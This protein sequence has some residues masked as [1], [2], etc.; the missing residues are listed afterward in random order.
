MTKW[1][2]REKVR[3]RFKA[4]PDAVQAKVRD[5]LAK[6]AVEISRAQKRLA[7]VEDGDLR[8]SLT[9]R[10]ATGEKI[11]YAFGSSA[12]GTFGVLVTA[13]NTKVRYAH[14]VEFGSAPH[15]VGGIFKGAQHPG[16]SPQPFFFP[17]YRAARRRVRARNRRALKAAV[18]AS[19]SS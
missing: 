11:K 9:W 8:A 10:W 18:A 6:S 3:R 2:G 15:K 12:K 19:S 16:T 17:A 13:G 7:P 4:L 14:I 1:I 5:S